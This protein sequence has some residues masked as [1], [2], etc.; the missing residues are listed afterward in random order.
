MY[1]LKYLP[2]RNS[3]CC[4]YIY[5][6]GLISFGTLSE[7]T[8]YR[9]RLYMEFAIYFHFCFARRDIRYYNTESLEVLNYEKLIMEDI[10]AA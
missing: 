9:S 3:K 2:F 4:F 8:K 10:M 5:K 6:D 1:V 7:A